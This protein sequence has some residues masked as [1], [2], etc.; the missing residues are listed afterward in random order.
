M[1][2]YCH[3]SLNLVL[4]KLKMSHKKCEQVIVLLRDQELGNGKYSMG[5]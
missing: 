2:F 1:L 5:P 4:I 3:T